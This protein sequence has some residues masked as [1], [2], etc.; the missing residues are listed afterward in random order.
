MKANNNFNLKKLLSVVLTAVTVLCLV[1]TVACADETSSASSGS[2]SASAS[3][4]SSQAAKTDYQVVTNGDF[5]FGTDETAAAN[6]P[7]SSSVN[8]TRSNDS[9]LNSAIS[10][11]KK[12]GII[13]T[14]EDKYNAI[15]E[16]QGFPYTEADGVKTYFNPKTPESYGLVANDAVYVYDEEKNNEGKLPTSGTKILMI[17]NVLEGEGNAERGTAQK[18]TSTKTFEVSYYGKIS[19]WIL[20]KDLKTKQD[21]DEFGAYVQLRTTIDEE[22]DPVVLKNI[23]TNGEWVQV[24]FYVAAH[25][26]AATKFRIVLGLGFGSKDV[27]QDYVEGFAYFDN[28]TYTE[29]TASEYAT[30]KAAADDEYNYYRLENGQN[31][32]V[33][34]DALVAS[35]PEKDIVANDNADHAFTAYNFAIDCA[36]DLE[37]LGE[38]AVPAI[39]QMLDIDVNDNY[40]YKDTAVIGENGRYGADVK[41]GL[42]KFADAVAESEL[43]SG[44]ENPFD[45]N[46]AAFYIVHPTNASSHLTFKADTPD[47]ED[48]IL[49]LSMWAKVETELNM[50]GLS[51]SLID[52]GDAT[53][54]KK[55]LISSF[56]TKDVDDE[57]H[58]GFV[59]ICIFITNN[60]GDGRA[61]EFDLVFDFGTTED[62][63]TEYNKLTTG[64]V[65]ITHVETQ[66]LTKEEYDKADSSTYVAMASLG[67]DMPNGIEKDEEKTDSYTFNYSET[68]AT[69]IMKQPATNVIDY[70]GVAGGHSRVGGESL[71]YKQEETKSGLINTKYLATY[72]EK[73][74]LTADE[75]TAIEALD[76]GEN[77][78]LQP[79]M[80]NNTALASYGYLGANKT[81]SAGATT[82]ISVK[83]K[84]YGDAKAYV[85]LVDGQFLNNYP[86]LKL[87]SKGYTFDATNKT[88]TTGT[89]NNKFERSLMQTVTAAD[90]EDGWATVTFV[91]TGG[92]NDVSYRVELWNGSRNGA[93]K[94]SGL[95]LFDEPTVTSAS[96]LS[97]LL[98]KSKANGATETDS[99]KYT[100]IP[101]T[102]NYTDDDGKEAVKY[103]TFNETTVYT[104]YS[105]KTVI[106]SYATLDVTTEETETTEEEDSA[107]DTSNSDSDSISGQNPALYIISMVIAIVLV[108]VLIVV[109]VRMFIKKNKKD[110]ISSE[111]YYSRDSREKAHKQIAEN[112]AR[113]EAAAKKQAE[114]EKLEAEKAA[115]EAEKAEEAE[116]P[117][118][119]EAAEETAEYDYENMENNI[120]A[121]A[122]PA[123]EQPAEEATEEQPKENGEDKPE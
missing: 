97:E 53:G 85:Y 30:A 16:E 57:E 59:K 61:R 113:R 32:P 90:C 65:L 31:K 29:L 67:A 51:I 5:E 64:Y 101:T 24:N 70:T 86:V 95:V 105:D 78:Q 123:E 27:R 41:A 18:F 35:F 55:T 46:D 69:Y 39:E 68:D 94:S 82:L 120:P 49:Y 98:A 17:H 115:A 111:T 4:S 14:A 84:V 106:A 81:L 56:T 92:E 73:G 15:A 44:I 75:K 112:K 76:R 19:L 66:F 45:E 3:P 52:K 25:D 11:A 60:V 83:V 80:I 58:K 100:R 7:V 122:V 110:K 26:Y 103:K 108:L 87:E 79:L 13:D 91:L 88:L 43:L 63:V 21:T 116:Q 54:A 34:K 42:K 109:V 93:E 72:V 48:G 114:A 77:E 104:A 74:Y 99:V 33:E 9:L 62:N 38:N 22:T 12:S 121:D 2:S 117:A 107:E 1:F 20:T 8:W 37:L 96:D 10:S 23:N 71:A 50:T 6:Y 28:V 102:V 118:E 47:N 119:E 40:L 89:D 36:L